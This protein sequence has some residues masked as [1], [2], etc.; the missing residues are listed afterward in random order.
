MSRNAT[1]I[2]DADNTIILH[3]SDMEIGL[4]IYKKYR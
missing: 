3:K 1:Q 4:K 2:Y